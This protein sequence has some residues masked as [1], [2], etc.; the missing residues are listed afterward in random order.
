MQ[1]VCK[2]FESR[3]AQSVCEQFTSTLEK[4]LMHE[5]FGVWTPNMERKDTNSFYLTGNV[6]IR[7]VGCLELQHVGD[8][9]D[10]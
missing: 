3:P 8:G 5:L 2:H 9:T 6:G 4:A 7:K 1:T 10:Y